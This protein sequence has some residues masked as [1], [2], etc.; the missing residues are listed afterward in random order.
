MPAR[1][2]CNVHI[3]LF[4]F[5]PDLVVRGGSLAF[6]RGGLIFIPELVVRGSSL[7]FSQ[8][9][10]FELSSSPI[11]FSDRVQMLVTRLGPDHAYSIG[12]RLGC[13]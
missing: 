10:Y 6:S 12:S 11:S 9:G 7:A 5:M 1:E 4:I 3:V 13:Q 8:G 2:D